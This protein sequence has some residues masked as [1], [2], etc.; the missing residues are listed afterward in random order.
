ML[1]TATVGRDEPIPVQADDYADVINQLYKLSP[2][3]SAFWRRRLTN[4]LMFDV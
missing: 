4:R 1:R 2:T 3:C